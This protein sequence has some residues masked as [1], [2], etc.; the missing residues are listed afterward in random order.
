VKK[1]DVMLIVAALAAGAIL[2]CATD[3]AKEGG[4][5]VDVEANGKVVASYPLDE[6]REVAL[7]YGGHNR[8]VIS[9]GA[10]RIVDADCPDL[11]CVKQRAVSKAGEVIV[12]LPHRLVVKVRGGVAPEVDGVSG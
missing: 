10:A 7:A 2:F 5:V 6:D 8:L 9:G 4:A 1:A 11:L 3:A 12:C